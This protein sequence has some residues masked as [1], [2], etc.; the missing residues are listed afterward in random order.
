MARRCGGDA[1]YEEYASQQQQQQQQ[2]HGVD[3][4]ALNNS[5]DGHVVRSCGRTFAP[6]QISPLK[7]ISRV[8]TMGAE[9]AVYD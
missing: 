8:A 6:T 5:Q 2:Q 3:A 1:V 9:S 7:V 4:R